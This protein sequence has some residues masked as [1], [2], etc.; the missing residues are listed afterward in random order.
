MS[1]TEGGAAARCRRPTPTS[2][3]AELAA[4]FDTE[5]PDLAVRRPTLEDT[6]LAMIRPFTGEEEAS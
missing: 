3:V 4:R 2:V 6:Y 5:V 1:W